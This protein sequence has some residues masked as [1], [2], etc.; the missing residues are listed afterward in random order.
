MPRV[1]RGTKRRARRKKAAETREGVFP[2]Q[3]KALPVGQ[4]SGESL[5]AIHLSRPSR[6]QARLPHVVDSAH[7][8]GSS[9]QRHHLQPVDSWAESRWY[10]AGPQD[11][12]GHGRERCGRI[13]RAGRIGQATCGQNARGGEG[14]KTRARSPSR[15]RLVTCLSRTAK[16][17]GLKDLSYIESQFFP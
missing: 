11:S 15:R 9:Q 4:G 17:S 14:C 16:P 3:G 7:R 13:H 10:R 2:H 6:P 5:P 1:K 12:G 8:R